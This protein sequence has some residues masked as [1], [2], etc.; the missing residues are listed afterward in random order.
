MKREATYFSAW[1]VTYDSI[2]LPYSIAFGRGIRGSL[3]DAYQEAK[4]RF[5]IITSLPFSAEQIEQSDADR[6]RFYLRSKRNRD[7]YGEEIW[8]LID[9]DPSLL[10]LYHQ[11]MGKVHARTYGKRLR[12]IGL[13]DAWIAIVEGVTIASG[14]T[15]D[16]VERI[17]QHILPAEKRKFA[18]IFHLKQKNR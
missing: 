18:Y 12:E 8:K 11:E 7:M 1:S 2:F 17:L 13:T 14:S 9:K 5:G 3:N 4:S 10:T 6:L 15:R 16:E